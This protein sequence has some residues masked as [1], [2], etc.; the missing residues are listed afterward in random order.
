MLIE[1]MMAERSITVG[2]VVYQVQPFSV[3]SRAVAALR[4]QGEKRRTGA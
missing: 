2:G 1:V 4:R 3:S